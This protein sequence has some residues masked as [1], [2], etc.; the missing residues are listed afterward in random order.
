MQRRTCASARSRCRDADSQVPSC[1]CT[2]VL[3]FPPAERFQNARADLHVGE[4][5]DAGGAG[6]RTEGRPVSQRSKAA[7]TVAGARMG[8]G[9][10]VLVEVC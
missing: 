10:G 3:L 8:R 1:M 5:M 2:E 9:V 6:T 4:E 7:L